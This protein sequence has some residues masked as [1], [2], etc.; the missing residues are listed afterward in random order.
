MNWE[1]IGAV[2]EL[3]GAIAVVVTLI[4][5]A[6]QIR[7]NTQAIRLDTGHDITEEYRDIFALMAE[8]R[9]LASLVERAA[10]DFES[11][12][13]TDK[14]QYYALN[15]NFVRALENAYIQWSEGAL[16]HRHWSGM[17]RMLSDYARIPAFREYWTNRK[18]W[19]SKEF[20]DFM[21]TEILDSEEIYDVPLPGQHS[22]S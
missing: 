21:E 15:S 19:F 9:E 6:I 17:K 12:Q 13:G 2:S 11:I 3:I 22:S 5:L 16:D 18:H 10:S 1:A 7:Q 14:V 4:Y 20:Q 8:N